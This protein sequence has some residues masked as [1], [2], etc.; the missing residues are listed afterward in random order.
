M[1]ITLPD[2]CEVLTRET[3]A[4]GTSSYGMDGE[5]LFQ[6]MQ[7]DN[8]YLAVWQP[9]SETSI[10]VT[11]TE[12]EDF[13]A[14]DMNGWNDALLKLLGDAVN[15]M[16]GQNGVVYGETEIYR[17]AQTRFLRT[18][19]ESYDEQGTLYGFD[20]Y[21]FLNGQCIHV[22]LLRDEEIGPENKAMLR[23]AVDSIRFDHVPAAEA[24]ADT[25][26]FSYTHSDSGVSFTVPA[27]WSS[28]PE[29]EAD[30]IFDAKFVYK[31]D[32][33]TQILFAAVDLGTWNAENDD[34]LSEDFTMEDLAAELGCKPEEMSRITFGGREYYAAETTIQKTLYGFELTLPYT[35]LLRLEGSTCY[36]FVLMGADRNSSCYRDFT[37]LMES[38]CYPSPGAALWRTFCISNLLLSLLI[39]VSLYTLPVVLY[40][41][42]FRKAPVEHKKAKKITWLYGIGAFVVM[43]GILSLLGQG[44]AGG[45]IVLW[46]WVNYRILICE[47]RKKVPQTAP[48]PAAVFCRKCGARL[49]PESRF[50]R[51]CGTRVQSFPTDFEKER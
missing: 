46:S 30:D 6:Y 29:E 11:M 1:E 24:D 34:L 10:L 51:K 43:T 15:T 31:Q 3:A 28:S 45:A 8:L 44:A 42:V 48:V 2:D 50:C 33:L 12:S 19:C 21:T 18:L 37:A 5:I 41:F 22:T 4:N 40:R 13:S 17:H 36:G 35:M 32:P 47:E 23:Q 16:S 25:P 39:T 38:V 9:E 26:A 7:E 14:I 20:Y 49:E 27:N